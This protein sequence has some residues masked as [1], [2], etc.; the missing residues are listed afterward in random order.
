MTFNK[1][2]DGNLI[3]W[4]DFYSGKKKVGDIH[5]EV[6]P[7]SDPF[8]THDPLRD[9]V[10]HIDSIRFGKNNEAEI[11]Y[12]R[13]DNDFNGN[14]LERWIQKPQSEAYYNRFQLKLPMQIRVKNDTLFISPIYYDGVLK[15]SPCS[16][17]GCSV[18]ESYERDRY[19]TMRC[20]I[21]DS[22]FILSCYNVIYGRTGLKRLSLNSNYIDVDEMI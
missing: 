21:I 10:I 8:E 16:E 7:S 20:K 14:L 15:F 22:G 4:K 9:P 17:Y 13:C 12:F 2:I 1:T 5:F 6:M 3:K 19:I 18:V 11:Y